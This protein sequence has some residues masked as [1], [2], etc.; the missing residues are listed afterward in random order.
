MDKLDTRKICFAEF[1][2]S[3]FALIDVR[4]TQKCYAH[5]CSRGS[6]GPK[7]LGNHSVLRTELKI[8]LNWI[9]KFKIELENS[10]LN[11][12]FKNWCKNQF[13]LTWPFALRAW[14]SPFLGKFCAKS[15]ILQKFA[16]KF[17]INF[18]NCKNCNFLQN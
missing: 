11:W 18:A 17:L 14:S 9:S 1:C 8:Q 2:S 10:K 12:K 4:K 6:L 16:S 3:F 15:Q 13:K 5:F 7:W